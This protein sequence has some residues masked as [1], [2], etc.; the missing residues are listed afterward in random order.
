MVKFPIVFRCISV[1]L[2]FLFSAL[3]APVTAKEPADGASLL[4]TFN[5]SNNSVER[6]MILKSLNDV[7]LQEGDKAPRWISDMLGTAMKD[8]SPVVVAEAAKQIGRFQ[9]MEYNADL[10]TLFSEA[11]SKFGASGY[12]HR[13]QYSVISALGKIGSKEAK[14]LVTEML[15]NDNGSAMGDYLLTAIKNFNDP[16]LI[17][18][19]KAYKARMDSLVKAAKAKGD[20]PILYSRKLRYS[21]FAAEIEKALLARGGK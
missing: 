21:E 14:T 9:L 16:A 3:N 7:T 5:T 15:K 11:D 4:N 6:R 8:K 1:I 10:I 20:D 12:T 2:L 18:E 17:A 13:V 19:L